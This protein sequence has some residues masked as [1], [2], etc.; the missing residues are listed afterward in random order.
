MQANNPIHAGRVD[1]SGENPGIY[2]KED[3]QGPWTG[4]MCFYRVVY[5]PHG[6]GSG[7]VV[8]D[9]PNIEKGRPD[10]DNFCICDNEPLAKYLVENFFSKFAAFKVSAGIKALSYL[11]LTSV[12]REGDTRS[13]Y[14]EVVSSNELEV[15]M[16]WEGL[17]DSY[18]V[19]MPADLG[20]TKQHDMY[21]FFVDA[22]NAQVSIN[23]R[24]L[25]GKLTS[26]NCGGTTKS[27]A[28]LAFSETWVKTTD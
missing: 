20:P 4:L 28:F 21:S 5:S 15:R 6:M 12:Q 13:T 3:P 23:G 1:W 25:R 10:V 2:L 26:R 18:A 27:S 8:L 14:S 22:S 17:S 16:T 19:N 7:V 11:P 24:P 9:E